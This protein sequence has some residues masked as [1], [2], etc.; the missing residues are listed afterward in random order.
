MINLYEL[1]Q[2]VAFADLG[3]LGRVAKEFHLSPRRL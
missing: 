3:T 2:L 1:R